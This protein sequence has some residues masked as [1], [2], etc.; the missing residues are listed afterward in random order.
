LHGNNYNQQFIIVMKR[1]SLLIA[2]ATVSGISSL[3]AQGD[4]DSHTHNVSISIPNI[5]ILD[6]ETTNAED[7]T[8]ALDAIGL[9]AGEEF[10]IDEENSDLWINYTSIL[11]ASGNQRSITVESSSIPSIA[12]LTLKVIASTHSGTG[13]GAVGIPTTVVTPSVVPTDIITGIG[14]S[15]TGN[16]NSNG[17]NL[18]YYLGFSGDFSD[19]NASAASSVIAMTYTIVD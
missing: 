15:F 7:V 10:I 16:G 1:T 13:G 17:H 14:S 2:F 9:D 12:G 4:S 3:Y 6:I 19:L 11:G 18:T 8:F 5:A